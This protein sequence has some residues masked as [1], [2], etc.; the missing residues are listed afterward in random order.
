GRDF[1]ESDNLAALPNR[2]D[3]P[4]PPGAD[5]QDPPGSPPRVA[6]VNEAFAR[7]FFDGQ[8]A[9]GRRFSI[10]DKWNAAKSYEIVAVVRDARYFD[11]RKAVEP[12]IYQPAFRAGRGGVG[13]MLCVRTTGDPN[14]MVETIRRRVREIA[15]AVAATDTRT[16]EDNLNRNLMQERFVATLGGLFGLVALLLAAIGL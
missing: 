16:M 4:P 1:R 13:G 12:M 14:R 11:L 8:S 5:L 15:G 6:I 10:D 3:Q 7:R 2:P 9:L